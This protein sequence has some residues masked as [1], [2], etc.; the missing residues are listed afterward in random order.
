MPLPLHLRLSST[1]PRRREVV[2]VLGS[3]ELDVENAFSRCQR[4]AGQN[5]MTDVTSRPT[6]ADTD[7]ARCIALASLSVESQDNNRPDYTG[8]LKR[9]KSHMPLCKIGI[10]Y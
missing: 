7:A 6:G 4:A 9:Q 10:S 8:C 5:R 1:A 3:L 2:I